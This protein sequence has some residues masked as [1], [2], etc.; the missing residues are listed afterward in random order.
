M[1]QPDRVDQVRIGDRAAVVTEELHR[2]E[3]RPGLDLFA[4]SK[5]RSDESDTALPG[6]SASGLGRHRG[7]ANVLTANERVERP[8]HQ[9]AHLA[10]GAGDERSP[11][12][13]GRGLALEQIEWE[14][15]QGEPLRL[16]GPRPKHSDRL[17][18]ERVADTC[19]RNDV[20]T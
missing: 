4:R 9:G 5:L 7:E 13:I 16:A 14:L 17:E 1:I 15:K 18:V 6:V 11:S 8:I 10:G 2:S 20:G 19:R 3:A 12:P